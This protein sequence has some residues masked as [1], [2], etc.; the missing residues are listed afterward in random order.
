MLARVRIA[1]PMNYLS[2]WVLI[3]KLHGGSSGHRTWIFSRCED[4][5][6]TENRWENHLHTLL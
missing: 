1:V 3:A 2:P 4:T 6:E 5:T